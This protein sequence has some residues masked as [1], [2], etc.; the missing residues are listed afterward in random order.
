MPIFQFT[1]YI[2]LLF[3]ILSYCICHICQ[4][5]VPSQN[6]RQH[7][8]SMNAHIP[9]LFSLLP[10]LYRSSLAI[11]ELYLLSFVLLFPFYL[12]FFLP[13]FL[14]P[15]IHFL[16]QFFTGWSWLAWNLVCRPGSTPTQKEL[17]VS[18][19]H[20]LGLKVC[21]TMPNMSLFL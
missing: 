9:L 18:A 1:C 16:I 11:N 8:A 10:L 15:P 17:L 14:C 5:I 3:F 19:S 20:V 6:H 13:S 2:H 12:I 7:F 21:T 4:M